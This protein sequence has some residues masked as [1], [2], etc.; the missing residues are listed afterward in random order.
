MFVRL[1]N[2]HIA[3]QTT[4]PGNV[5]SYISEDPT[6]MRMKASDLVNELHQ[7]ISTVVEFS[8]KTT[9]EEQLHQLNSDIMRLQR[10]IDELR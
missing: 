2:E 5:G 10:E 7:E 9:F 8:L 4:E 6:S 1:L 3:R